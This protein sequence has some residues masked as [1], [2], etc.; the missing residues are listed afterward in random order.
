MLRELSIHKIL[1]LYSML[2]TELVYELVDLLLEVLTILG[3]ELSSTY[4]T[5]LV[6]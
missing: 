3:D 4:L 5:T 1:K 6:I 2:I